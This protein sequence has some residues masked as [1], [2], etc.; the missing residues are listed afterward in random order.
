MPN[1]QYKEDKVAAVVTR[2]VDGD[3]IKVIIGNKEETVRFLGID[4][5]ENVNHSKAE[6][7]GQ[8]ATLKVKEDLSNK[9]ILLEA[10]I[11]Q[12]NQDD[13]GRLL[14][15]VFLKDGRNFNKVMIEDGLAEE[16]FYRGREYKYRA[17]FLEAENLAKEHKVGLWGVC[18]LY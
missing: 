9:E 10:D 7:Y 1:L 14:R 17:E 2:V 16:Y 6:C 4:A 3:T 15:Y 13:Y 12:D 5:P 11:L 8:E 18:K